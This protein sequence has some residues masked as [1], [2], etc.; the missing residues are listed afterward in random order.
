MEVGVG[1][2]F[3][4]NDAH[5][6]ARQAIH[7]LE[8]ATSFRPTTSPWPTEPIMGANPNPLGTPYEGRVVVELWDTT[9]VVAV[10][11]LSSSTTDTV[12]KVI[13]VLRGFT[14]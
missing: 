3:M 5:Q 8:T 11:A 12:T 4:P 13:T 9:A 14:P 2:A 7:T 6:F 1:V 10:T